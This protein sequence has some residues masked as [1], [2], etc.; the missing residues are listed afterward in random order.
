MS[1]HHPTYQTGDILRYLKGAMSSSEMRELELKALN[2]PFLQDAIDGYRELYING[3]LDEIPAMMEVINNPGQD[4]GK[5]DKKILI[6]VWRRKIVRYAAAA[7]I[8]TGT[9][10]FLFDLSQPGEP[11]IITTETVTASTGALADSITSPSITLQKTEEKEKTPPVAAEMPDTEKGAGISG[12]IS[13]PVIAKQKTS[14]D[15]DPI[16]PGNTGPFENNNHQPAPATNKKISPE[17]DHPAALSYKPL[18]S[19]LQEDKMETK[20]LPRSPVSIRGKVVDN[21]KYPLDNISIRVKET[22]DEVISDE[23]GRFQ[24]AIPD[25]GA[26][27]VA[28]GPGYQ[29][30]EF[31]AL[32]LQEP[33]E[34]ELESAGRSLEDAV[35]M[36]YRRKSFNRSGPKP[37]LEI[38]T[39]DAAPAGGWKQFETYILKNKRLNKNGKSPHAVILSFEVNEKG[40]PIEFDII[41]SA[42]DNWSR[43]AIR[44][45]EAGPA[46]INKTKSPGPMAKITV[47]F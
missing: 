15:Q 18:V 47:Q 42:G 22:S 31:K 27:L 8:I 40:R 12:K 11:A 20:Q 26:T 13:P 9:G 38:D 46:W 29:T 3:G 30:R 5:K 25:T 2:D 16:F 34:L 32:A 21:E 14:K 39:T 37:Y 4:Q 45:L 36:S 23:L 6:P 35:V 1:N 44:L 28:N 10:W 43:E 41:T 24:V 17:Q 33:M 7:A 19:S